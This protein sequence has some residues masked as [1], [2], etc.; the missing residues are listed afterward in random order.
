MTPNLTQRNLTTHVMLD[1]FVTTNYVT[2]IR[3]FKKM[4]DPDKIEVVKG[5]SWRI[6]KAKNKWI[7]RQTIVALVVNDL[8]GLVNGDIQLL[9]FNQRLMEHVVRLFLLIS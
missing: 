8:L 7:R 1:E 5:L 9:L 3:D 4:S 6:I 2:L